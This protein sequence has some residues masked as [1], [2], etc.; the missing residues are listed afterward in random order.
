MVSLDV[1]SLFTNIPLG[2]TI[3]ICIDSLYKDDENSPKIP[4]DFFRNL[5]PWPPKNRFLCLTANSINKSS[6]DQAEKFKKCFSSKH[7][8][9]KF[10]LEKENDGRLSFLDINI[11]REK[12]KFVTNVIGKRLSVV[13]I[14]R[15]SYLKSTK[16]V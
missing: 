4:K 16:P 11:F 13:L 15:A 1:D 9:I 14:L 10:S 12:G 8:N 5:L 6:L 7:P 2:E 3:D